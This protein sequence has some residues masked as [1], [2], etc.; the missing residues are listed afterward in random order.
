MKL[1]REL[2]ATRRKLSQQVGWTRVLDAVGI[3]LFNSYERSEFTS[4]LTSNLTSD[5]TSDLT[6][7]TS[8]L[9]FILLRQRWF[10]CP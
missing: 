4:I 9:I 6:S 2:C 7:E 1:N 5:L 3:V 10:L 8:V